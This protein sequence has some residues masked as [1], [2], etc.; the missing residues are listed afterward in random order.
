MSKTDPTDRQWTA[1][2]AKQAEGRLCRKG[3]PL[4]PGHPWCEKGSRA[5]VRNRHRDL[6]EISVLEWSM[7]GDLVKLHYKLSGHVQWVEVELE[8]YVLEE[9]LTKPMIKG[10]S[11]PAKRRGDAKQWEIAAAMIALALEDEK[12]GRVMRSHSD[13]VIL[14]EAHKFFS[15]P[16]DV[17]VKAMVDADDGN[18]GYE[19]CRHMLKAAFGVE[20]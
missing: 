17:R 1:P 14:V 10:Y 2:D 19:R 9:V 16:E 7:S 15:I 5:I 12:D 8:E 18:A 3:A 13:H 4:K 6:V 11:D 20:V